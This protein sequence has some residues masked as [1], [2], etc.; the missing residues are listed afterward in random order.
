[1]TARTRALG[2]ATVLAID[3]DVALR[4]GEAWAWGGAAIAAALAGVYGREWIGRRPAQAE[5][6]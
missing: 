2:F 4:G 5:S 3:L 6:R 1:M